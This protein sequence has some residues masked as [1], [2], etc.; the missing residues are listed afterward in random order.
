ME[1]R[2][3]LLDALTVLDQPVLPVDVFEEFEVE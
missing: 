2:E 3:E 1:E